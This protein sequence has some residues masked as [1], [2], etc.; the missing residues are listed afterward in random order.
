MSIV[1]GPHTFS[2]PD[3]KLSGLDSGLDRIAGQQFLSGGYRSYSTLVLG[4]DFSMLAVLDSTGGDKEVMNGVIRWSDIIA[5]LDLPSSPQ[6]L[7]HPRLDSLGVTGF[8]AI[9]DK[10]SID[11]LTFY[12][13][14]GGRE[15]V[16]PSV[17]A[18]YPGKNMLLM[19]YGALRFK[20]MS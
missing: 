4:Q 5:L 2:S 18:T 6:S 15:P 9:F 10:K 14:L 7:T 3:L 1:F 12:S 11:D 8:T 16:N 17:D 19:W 13:P 20:R